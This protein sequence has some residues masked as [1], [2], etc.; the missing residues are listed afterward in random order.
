MR[1][2]T[3]CLSGLGRQAYEI[4]GWEG[5]CLGRA[6]ARGTESG[7]VVKQDGLWGKAGGQFRATAGASSVR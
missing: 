3:V 1:Q 2:V 4:P 7:F 6:K 5:P